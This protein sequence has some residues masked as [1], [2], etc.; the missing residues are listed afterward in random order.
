[1]D[2]LPTKDF[3]GPVKLQL[4]VIDDGNDAT[5]YTGDDLWSISNYFFITVIPKNDAPIIMDVNEQ[6]PEEGYLEFNAT[7]NQMFN[8]TINASDI[9]YDP[10]FPLKFIWEFQ[11]SQKQN[12]I[13]DL[14]LER[15]EERTIDESG[16]EVWRAYLSY[17][18][19]Q[20]EVN[21]GS[22]YISL[23]VTD[24]N[25][26]NPLKDIEQFVIRIINVNDA[27]ILKPIENYQVEEDS[28]LEGI[29]FAEDPDRDIL[30]ITTN[31]TDNKGDDD[32]DNFFM[33][34]YYGFF[35]FTPDNDNV[36]LIYIKVTV[37]D[38]AGEN[39]SIVTQNFQILVINTPDPPGINRIKYDVVDAYNETTDLDE[40][41]TVHFST[42]PPDDDDLPYGDTIS[43]EWDFDAS[44][45]IQIESREQNPTWT[46]PLQA[47]YE[48]TLRVR[49]S[50]GL[51]NQTKLKVR[52]FTP[53]ADKDKVE[54]EEGE[55]IE[56][57]L[58][59]RMGLLLL[60]AIIIIGIIV[61]SI[62]SAIIKKRKVK[63]K[64]E[65]EDVIPF[66]DKELKVVMPEDL[67]RELATKIRQEKGVYSPIK[68]LKAPKEAKDVLGHTECSTPAECTPL[69]PKATEV[70]VH[71][72]LPESSGEEPAVAAP[73]QLPPAPDDVEASDAEDAEQ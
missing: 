54:F 31:V 44:N 8:L 59:T 3:F 4:K 48:V 56:S 25:G 70:D 43:Y 53:P 13:S 52:V 68:N 67:A 39:N 50:K 22:V 23:T 33:D 64:K 72:T 2:V 18:P 29:I 16:F 20:N 14:N 49:D 9:D 36:G 62:I 61:S 28:T 73:A 41:L 40:N 65:D 26:S 45:G 30:T 1:M 21:L 34:S 38:N 47:Q 7:E 6:D 32:L 10:T 12:I 71:V 15:S 17:I 24:S 19:D 55:S 35:S 57:E 51:T 11:D 37:D 27:P 60:L 5:P 69:I 66:K 42:D 63:E 58:G 46:F